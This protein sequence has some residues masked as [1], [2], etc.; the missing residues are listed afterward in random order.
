MILSLISGTLFRD[1]ETR[2]GK[3]GEFTIATVKHLDGGELCFCRVLAFSDEARAE[4]TTLRRGDALTVVGR[5][6]AEIYTPEGKEPAISFA[7][8]ADRVT[9][10]R[11]TPRD[12]GAHTAS[13]KGKNNGILRRY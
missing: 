7:I 13:T 9:G 8:R 1:P 5:L 2:S 3:G 11:M 4:L 10:L 12:T 6:D